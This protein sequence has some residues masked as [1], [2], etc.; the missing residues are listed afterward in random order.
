MDAYTI[1]WPAVTARLAAAAEQDR[2]WY[3]A[4]AAALVRSADRTA[5]DVGCGGG[6]MAA[7][8]AAALGPEGVVV[9][10][11]GSAEVLAAAAALHPGGIRWVR[12]DLDVDLSPVREATGGAANLVWASGSVHHAADQQ[13]AVTALAGLLA[14]G[15]RLALAEGGL[16]SR[17]LPWDVGVGDPGLEVRLDAAQ[18]RWFARM[19]AALPGSVPMPYGWPEA[20]RR[21]G[22]AG[23]RSTSMLIER[24]GP[25][26][27]DDR[28]RA[29]TGLVEQVDRL[30]PTG[31]LDPGDLAAWDRL[32]D[33]TGPDFLGHRDD[34]CSLAARTVHTGE[35]PA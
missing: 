12:A 20:L 34:L 2:D 18:D 30:H 25:L 5:V 28:T 19:R 1:D 11:D 10:T 16:P 6:G 23:V 26:T 3:A 8:L 35:R 21:A 32:L 14:S 4:T 29:V 9:G 27:G 24:P 33:P 31:L 22:L 17:R 7:E 13:A 15:G